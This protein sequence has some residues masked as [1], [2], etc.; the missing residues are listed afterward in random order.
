MSL[1]A[2]VSF[3]GL[4]VV[5]LLIMNNSLFVGRFAFSFFFFPISCKYTYLD[6]YSPMKL[7]SCGG[8]GSRRVIGDGAS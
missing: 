4:E 8:M 2:K 5:I 7:E 1:H 6:I 3:L